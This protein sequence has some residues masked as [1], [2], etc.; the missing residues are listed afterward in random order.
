MSDDDTTATSSKR[1]PFLKAGAGAVAVS[2]AGCTGDEGGEGTETE[3]QGTEEIT[4]STP[5]QVEEG[6]VPEGGSFRYGMSQAP[7]GMNPLATS[8]SYSWVVLDE[9]L[10]YGTSIDPVTFEVQPSAYTDWTVE[11]VDSGEPDVYFNIR[12][13]ITWSDGEEFTV[14][15]VLFTYNFIMEANPGRYAATVAPIDTV[16]EASNDWDVHLKLSNP[17]GTYDSQQL[18]LPLIPE[19]RWSDVSADSFTEYQPQENTYEVDGEEYLG[20]VGLGP[21]RLTRYEPDTSVEVQYRDDYTLNDL[22]W[23]EEHDNLRAGG[24]FL[25]NLRVNIYGSSD[26]LQ[27]AFISE[28]AIDSMFGSVLPANI[29]D[30]EDKEGARI[31]TGSDTGYAHYSFNMRR[32]PFD[33]TIFRQALGLVYDQIYWIE[34]LNRGTVQRGAFTMP[35]GYAAVRPE[36]AAD[37]AE[38]NEHPATKAFDFLQDQPGVPDYA[39]IKDFLRGGVPITG[40]A[41]EGDNQ[42]IPGRDYPGSLT[43]VT[44]GDTEARHEYTWGSVESDVLADEPGVE[45][46]IRVNGETITEINGQ[47]LQILMYPPQDSPLGTQMLEDWVSKLKTLG[48]PVERNVMTFNTMLTEVYTN[49]N[50]GAFPMSWGNL[51]PF[52]APSLEG[53]FHSS[54]AHSPDEIGEVDANNAMGY[55]TEGLPGADDL[56]DEALQTMDAE[57]RNEVA[58]QAV[59]KV[60]LDYPTQV[61]SHEIPQWPVNEADFQ[62]YVSGI[63]SPGSNY[64]SVQFSQIHQTE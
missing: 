42:V 8:S 9:L 16:E 3:P 7:E 53:L 59:E 18:Q 60:Y 49:V 37:D 48:V 56:I 33:D 64:V 39:A 6:D 51:S 12:E 27:Q 61:N 15:D 46:E 22:S 30:V 52:G 45:E 41:A 17:V 25:D 21:G 4:E 34:Q 29:P 55:G 13:G 54:Q 63:P 28:D 26:A 23:Y 19:H 32:T 44:A 31:V 38:I 1:R 10:A 11:N 50:F 36:Q 5:E 58:R 24:P 20:P 2:L 62:G 35:P 40:E 57:A 43:G 14:D 47:P